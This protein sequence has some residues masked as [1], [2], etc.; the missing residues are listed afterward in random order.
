MSRSRAAVAMM[1]ALISSAA[2]ARDRK[3]E[4]ASKG[5]LHTAGRR[6]PNAARC[7]H[8]HHAPTAHIY[9]SENADQGASE[10][11]HQ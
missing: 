10:P 3:P 4:R 9:G 5:T 7:P 6:R 11:D 1:L 2:E 8:R